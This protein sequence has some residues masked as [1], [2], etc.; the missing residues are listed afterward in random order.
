MTQ[1]AFFPWSFERRYPMA[2]RSEGVYVYDEN[3]KRYLDGSGGAVAVTIGH[4]VRAVTDEIYKVLSSLSY[5]HNSHFRT[6][7]GEELATLLAEFYPGAGQ[8]ARVLFASGGSEATE[9]AIK[10]VRQYWLSENEP[11]R[12]KIIS[13][14]HGYHGATLG[15]LGLSGNRRRRAPYL[16][17]LPQG[18]HVASCFC[19]HC[20]FGLTFPSCA[21]AC[22]Q[23]LEELIRAEGA[24][25][26]AALILEPVVGATS[27]AVPPDGYL[28]EI[29]KIC[30]RHGILLIADE[31]MTGSGRTGRYFAVEHWS[32]QP[33]L[34]L[35]GKG[36]SSGYAPLGAVLVAE[37]VWRPIE[38]AASSLEHSF[39]YQCHPPSLAAG[40]A[41][42]R[43]V[44]QNNLVE[45]AARRG[46]YLQRKLEDLRSFDCV[47]DIRGKGLLW[48]MEFLENSPNR[49]PY[50]SECRF[51]ERLF[52]H[53]RENGVMLY[54]GRGTVDGKAGDHILIAP[55]FVIE[56]SQI[57][58][59]VQQL[60]ASI[61]SV[62]EGLR[63][64]TH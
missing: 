61:Q 45:Q 46:D 50:P 11:K 37:R 1:S 18:H 16:D 28:T 29:R 5:A 42:Q 4:S 19:Y 2:V 47:G 3:G 36:L 52:E 48:T 56:E 24:D 60:A 41:V 62:A 8:D 22:A 21:L 54:P 58:F 55:P 33:D 25:T 64:R 38:K 30:D 31:I 32:V 27:G 63:F 10:V 7:I 53:L 51:S 6:R 20:P 43:Y 17:L 13:R 34:I 44:R 9:T 39:T 40:L 57:D 14:W 12:Y 49:L 15:A 59:M 23:E 26:V 35:M